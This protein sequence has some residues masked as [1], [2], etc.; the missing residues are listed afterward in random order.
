MLPG[1]TYTPEDIVQ[2]G[3]RRKWWLITPLVLGT[4]IAVAVGRS[5]P[6]T[7]RSET[8]I[9]LLQQRVPDSYVK[10]TVTAGLQERL[11][12]LNQ[13]ILSRSRLERIILDFDLYSA[14]R[15]ILPM[16]DVVE[17]MRN[18]IDP[19]KIENGASFRLSYVGQ[20]SKTVQKVTARLASLFI[21]ENTR[22]R[23]D[24]AEDTNQ[25]IDAQLEDARR[26]L[27]EQEKKLEEYRR[28]HSGELPSQSTSNLQMIQN[29]QLQLQSLAE[30]EDR[31]RER[32]LLLER[33]LADL[34]YPDPLTADSTVAVPPSSGED[35]SSGG[36]TA[37]QLEAVQERLRA[38]ELRLTPDHPDI[39][40]LR[41]TAKDL[42]AKLEAEARQASSKPEKPRP[43]KPAE[44]ARQRRIRDLQAQMGDI[45]RQLRDK[46]EQNRR[47]MSTIAD[48]QS[49]L[50]ALPKRESE[51]V[52]LTRDY[53]TLQ[54]T[55]ASLLQ[56]RE[57]SKLA[58][59]LERR[60]IGEQFRVLD[61]AKEAERPFSPNRPLIHFIGA[62]A[63]LGLGLLL[64]GLFEYR[65]SSFRTEDDLVRVLNLPVL[66][67]VPTIPAKPDRH[68]LRRAS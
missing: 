66:A 44:I 61:P 29:A 4:A 57:S 47:L 36:T 42:E 68:P 25:F 9:M 31:D 67:L 58:L 19:I 60:N 53:T 34:D 35:G 21:E 50:G 18:D 1:K 15:K 33:Q 26:R 64:V 38:A 17:G 39:R 52:E 13:Q 54:Q 14:E 49:K 41:R 6:D 56:N 48:Y 45:D 27:I 5:M 30:A 23:E 12:T 11:T 55:Y 24:L 63:G 28:N 37:Q 16:E 3:W 59:N 32:R 2:I 22:D 20:D 43:P 46:Q 7:Y 10:S 40:Y 62:A 8:I 65:D 51:L